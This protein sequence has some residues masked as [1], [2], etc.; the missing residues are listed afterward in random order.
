MSKELLL[1]TKAVRTLIE[2]PDKWTKRVYARDWM[3]HELLYYDP[4]AVSYCLIGAHYNTSMK[5]RIR[6]CEFGKE[7]QK[8]GLTLG[9]RMFDNIAMF[10]DHPKTQHKDVLAILDKMIENLS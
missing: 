2:T 8:A 10:N 1:H 6:L 3:G 9:Y 7:F 5:N 4:T